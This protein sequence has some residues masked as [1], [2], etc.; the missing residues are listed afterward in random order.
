MWFNLKMLFV[1]KCSPFWYAVTGQTTLSCQS[2]K[3]LVY[4]LNLILFYFL[5]FCISWAVTQ[6]AQICWN[7]NNGQKKTGETGCGPL[8]VC[9]TNH[10]MLKRKQHTGNLMASLTPALSDLKAAEVMDAFHRSITFLTEHDP[11]WQC[12]LW[13]HLQ[14]T[15]GTGPR[16]PTLWH[17]GIIGVKQ[18]GSW[19]CEWQVQGVFVSSEEFALCPLHGIVLAAQ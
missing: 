7:S 15:E 9:N 19:M 1:S 5:F 13:N 14:H 3:F 4:W 10:I 12:L 16:V 8:W 6:F 2:C 18:K 11:Q 17:A